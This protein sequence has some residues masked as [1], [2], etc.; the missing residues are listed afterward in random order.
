MDGLDHED[1]NSNILK[2]GSIPNTK[3]PVLLNRTPTPCSCSCTKHDGLYH[4]CNC[5]HRHAVTPGITQEEVMEQETKLIVLEFLSSLSTEKLT[6]RYKTNENE[7]EN[8]ETNKSSEENTEYIKP[9]RKSIRSNTV[10]I[11]ENE[12]KELM[13]Q[14]KEHAAREEENKKGK[15][16]NRSSSNVT[17]EQYSAM[18]KKL[19]QMQIPIKKWINMNLKHEIESFDKVQLS[20]TPIHEVVPD[21]PEYGETLVA[22]SNLPLRFV[23]FIYIGRS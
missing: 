23:M 21:T 20:S 12:R 8:S 5:K 2:H 3:Q 14:L 11:G 17:P 4:I 19:L 7:N 16:L 6:A 1:V 15:R 9:D 22:Q 10:T 13:R 18:R